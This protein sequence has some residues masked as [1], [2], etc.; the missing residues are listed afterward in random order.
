MSSNSSKDSQFTIPQDKYG[1]QILTIE[2]LVRGNFWYY[3]MD[4]YFDDVVFPQTRTSWI[5]GR[6]QT[7]RLWW[8][9]RRSMATEFCWSQPL[10]GEG[11]THVHTGRDRRV[12]VLRHKGFLFLLNLKV[13]VSSS[14]RFK[15]LLA[16][17]GADGS[18]NKEVEISDVKYKIFQVTNILF[19]S[20]FFYPT[21]NQRW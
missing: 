18:P 17:P 6:C 12:T 13:F 21:M 14:F 4:I 3:Y 8:R 1:Q 2:K 10:T 15:F 20:R 11:H 9:G 16:S 19:I 5:T 7:W